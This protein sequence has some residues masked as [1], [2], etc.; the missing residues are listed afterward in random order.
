MKSQDVTNSKKSLL[1]QEIEPFISQKNLSH[2]SRQAYYYDLEQFCQM[3]SDINEKTLLHYRHFLEGL[4]K[5]AQQR[6][7]S[8]VNQFLYFLYQK[9]IIPAFYKIE[10]STRLKSQVGTKQMEPLLDWSFLYEEQD[11]SN[12]YLIVLLMIDLGLLPSEIL[13]IK[14]S[15]I[16]L[17]FRILT[18]RQGKLQRTLALSA[19]VSSVLE[20]Q[21]S[22][23]YL[24]DH[25]GKPYTRQWLFHQLNRYLIEIGRET[26]TAQ[27]LREQF[28][29]QQVKEG[30]SILELAKALGLKTTVTLE[31]YYQ[32]NGY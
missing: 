5:S 16:D 23:S 9:N 6:K 8:A 2:N 22:G 1:V 15:D 32:L 3:V 11:L 21:L 31:K 26:L 14:V 12:G 20:K 13:G 18:I 7:R 24:F 17:T 30:K 29:L 28:I 10:L 25:G 27:K 19:F 4:S